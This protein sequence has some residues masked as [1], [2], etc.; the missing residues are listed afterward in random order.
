MAI[1]ECVFQEN[2]VSPR[3]D[4]LSAGTVLEDFKQQNVTHWPLVERN[5]KA[6]KKHSVGEGENA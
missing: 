4:L 5:W 6:F 2:E 3:F 1:S